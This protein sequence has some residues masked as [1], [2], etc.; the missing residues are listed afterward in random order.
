MW[1]IATIAV[2]LVGTLIVAGC[3]KQEPESKSYEEQ[4]NLTPQPVTERSSCSCSSLIS[5]NVNCT[6]SAG[7]ASCTCGWITSTCKCELLS[8]SLE[9]DENAL[10]ELEDILS[11]MT[12]TESVSVLGLVQ[13]LPDAVDDYNSSVNPEEYLEIHES[14]QT[15]L[16]SLPTSEKAVLNTWII[17]K[18]WSN[19]IP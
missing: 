16:P 1:L 2:C 18:G 3:F 10:G 19:T 13:Q 4:A 12:S 9:L 5:C 14:L 8:S 7:S 17:S 15:Q 6:G 11:S